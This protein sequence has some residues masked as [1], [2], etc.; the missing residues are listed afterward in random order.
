[1]MEGSFTGDRKAKDRVCYFGDVEFSFGSSMETY[2]SD[3]FTAESLVP[4]TV[5]TTQKNSFD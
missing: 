2:G 1:M 3:L 5:F 4:R